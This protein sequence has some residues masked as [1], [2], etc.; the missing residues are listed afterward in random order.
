MKNSRITP[1]ERGLLK[2]AIR[3]V[4]SRSDLR[5]EALLT[6]MIPH[7]DPKRPRVTKWS[8]CSECKEFIPTYLMQVDHKNPI[9]PVDQSFEDM[10]FDD[11]IDRLWCN[12]EE[13]RPLCKPC[14]LIKSKEENRLRR[15]F[16]KEK[17]KK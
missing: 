16:K 10:N 1:K 4:F 11:L 2:G 8:T 6:T 3:R 12:K 13:L 14:H 15:Q 9:V 5:R 17:S 7:K